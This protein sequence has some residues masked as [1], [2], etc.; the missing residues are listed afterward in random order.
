M[1]CSNDDVEEALTSI[2]KK[3]RPCCTDILGFLLLVAG[4]GFSVLIFWF[5]VPRT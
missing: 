3:N 4:L 2:E 5:V 1:C